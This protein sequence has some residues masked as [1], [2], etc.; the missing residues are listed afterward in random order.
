M[1]LLLMVLLAANA[2]IWTSN[3]GEYM[4]YSAV[5]TDEDYRCKYTNQDIYVCK[6][7]QT[8]QIKTK[9]QIEV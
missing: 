5:L 3:N 6:S 8:G 1:K 4:V 9:Y 2:L 7:M